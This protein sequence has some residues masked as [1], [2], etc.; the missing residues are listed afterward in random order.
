MGIPHYYRNIINT[1]RNIIVPLTDVKCSNLFIDFN[2]II[3]Q[4]ANTVTTLNPNA[5]TSQDIFDEII[6]NTNIL[7]DKC[8][9]TNLVYIAVDGVAP[10]AKMV[11]QR[12]RR[13]LAQMKNQMISD[14][15]EKN[16]IKNTCTWDSNII[17][18]G[19]SFM[20][21]LNGIL[22]EHFSHSKHHHQ[23]AV[24]ISG[25]D[26]NGEGEQKIFD[27]LK[28]VHNNQE[29]INIISGLDADLIMLSLL[30]S[31]EKIYLLRDDSSYVDINEFRLSIMKHINAVNLSHNYM[32]DYVFLCFFIGND[33][34]PSLPFLKINNGAIDVL[35]ASYRKIHTSLNEFFVIKDDGFNIN[36]KFLRLLLKDLAENEH[37]H[38]EF[39]M[40]HYTNTV[41]VKTHVVSVQH[42]QNK[43]M[44]K[45]L[46]EL[47]QYPLINKH[48]LIIKYQNYTKHNWQHEY[49][50]DLCGSDD[51]NDIQKYVKSYV[52][53]LLW[54]LNYYFNRKFDCFWYYR[55]NVSPF[56]KDIYQS[57]LTA[58]DECI[59]KKQQ[60]LLSNS[61]EFNI[62]PALQLLC[63]LPR[64]SIERFLPDC[65]NIVD[66]YFYMYPLSFK[67][68]T[69]L[70]QFLWE[71]TPIVPD[72]D[73]SRLYQAITKNQ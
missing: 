51:P 38:M 19:T 37:E 48:P 69:F 42:T 65:V 45:Y 59:S 66:K 55:Y 4:S 11:Q 29:D 58:S 5:Y 64:Q 25:S 62:T 10:R 56:A 53:G 28:D 40:N 31:N 33:F 54:T 12:K 68:C 6:R 49:Y 57:L 7:I 8:K 9:P 41:G 3:H 43:I 39:A 23:C 32:Y 14:F 16:M 35:L 72:I 30:A 73:I 17:T 26:E 63:V 61:L 22:H 52:D 70:K 15:L 47:E 13:Y 46:T 20:N 36:A 2:S 21:E 71:C 44:K 34:L 60:T 24:I 18:P 67:L 50:I 27:Y 1:Y